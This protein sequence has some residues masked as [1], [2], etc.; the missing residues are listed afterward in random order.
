[1][2]APRCAAHPAAISPPSRS[3]GIAIDD[4]P[5]APRPARSPAV[6][7]EAA[8]S[9]D[10]PALGDALDRALSRLCGLARFV[11]PGTR[12]FLKPNLLSAKEPEKAVTTHPALVGALAARCRDLGA[13]VAI[14][15][16]PAGAL[17]GIRRVW[18]KTG[19]EEAARATGA[20]LVSL[21]ASGV[22][23]RVVRGRRYLLSRPVLEADL[24]VNLP[25]LKTHGLTLFTG[26]VKNTF[27]AVPGLRKG[28]YHK[29][30]PHPESF[31]E[32]MVDIHAVVAPALHVMDGVLAMEGNGP[33]SGRPRHLGLLL[34]S[35][36]GVALDAVASRLVGFR[37]E[38]IDTTRIGAA[39]GLTAARGLAAGRLDGVPVLGV[40]IA[41][42][43]AAG[44]AL[45][46]NRLV[47]VVPE[48][49]L[50][51]AGRL[52]WVRPKADAATCIG[53]TLCATSC[54]V[55]AITMV[56]RLPRIDYAGCINCI[57]C[58][59]VCPT[60]AMRAETS[61]FAGVFF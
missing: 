51:L 30:A 56:D 29:E 31:A 36:D 13:R 58:Q 47:K 40:P 15:D 37:P 49:L 12:V 61:P 11:R 4:P 45:P 9:Y 55:G 53:C 28:E 42:A 48:T 35:E 39:R 20:A 60:Q 21:E 27:G 6:A 14:G 19:M 33:A 16:S 1:M 5:A 57:S 44:F 24:V 26:A 50:R 32:I 3:P 10:E 7:I 54:P 17:K 46:S 8:P 23:E 52:V 18:R 43:R 38:M 2:I 22:V 34:A 41:E 59:E 25:K